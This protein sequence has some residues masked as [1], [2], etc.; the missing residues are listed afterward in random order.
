MNT[1]F[2]GANIDF[3]YFLLPKPCKLKYC[4][5]EKEDIAVFF[6]QYDVNKFVDRI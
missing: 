6:Y 5:F 3:S 4:N 2:L 1:S